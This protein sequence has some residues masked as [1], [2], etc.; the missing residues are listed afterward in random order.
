MVEW[1]SGKAEYTEDEAASALGI[2][3]GQLRSLVR[4]HVI[5]EETGM[6]VPIPS[7]RPTDLLLL[8]M[9]S[10][11]QPRVLRFRQHLEQ[12]QVCRPEARNG[13]IHSRLFLDHM[14]PNQRPQLAN[15]YAKG[16]SGFFFRVF[17]FSR[18]PLHHPL[19]PSPSLTEL[20]SILGF[21]G[22]LTQSGRV[23]IWYAVLPDFK[24]VL[25]RVQ[26]LTG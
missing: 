24:L 16:G 18:N 6:D 25:F 3:V 10:E 22:D 26:G 14:R 12:Q 15:G 5:K 11:S 4:T 19:S 17:R 21:R 2:S 1:V 9:L 8:K 7:F 20:L 13:N 23:P